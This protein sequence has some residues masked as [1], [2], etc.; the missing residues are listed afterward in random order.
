MNPDTEYNFS[1]L[2]TLFNTK[3]LFLSH[4]DFINNVQT[5]I[6]TITSQ[7]EEQP[8]ALLIKTEHQQQAIKK[9]WF[10]IYTS[11]QFRYL[12]FKLSK[13]PETVVTP[14]GIYPLLEDPFAIYQLG[15]TAED[16]T[17]SNILPG[18]KMS[19]KG[20][21]TLTLSFVTQYHTSTTGIVLLVHKKP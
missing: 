21:I 17:N 6:K 16:Y 2:E 3:I 1:K 10:F 5:V 19:L 18:N 15:T 20:L 7:P 14:Y 13:I 11:L 4:R 9:L 12:K 8:I